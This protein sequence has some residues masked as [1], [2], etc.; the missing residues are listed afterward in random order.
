MK[1]F[2]RGLL[3]CVA[4][5]AVLWAL[6][7]SYATQAQDE[8]GIRG[9]KTGGLTFEVYKDAKGE[10]RWRLKAANNQIIGTSGEGYRAKADCMNAIDTIKK[11][12][13]TATVKEVEK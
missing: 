10:F 2:V 13:A 11:G 7:G 3:L 4:A 9:G 5:L 12:A 8:V 6:S 1:A